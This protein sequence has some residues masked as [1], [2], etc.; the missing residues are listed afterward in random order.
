MWERLLE[1]LQKAWEWYGHI[2][3][4][5]SLYG[6]IFWLFPAGGFVSLLAWLTDFP[7]PFIVLLGFAGY[8]IGLCVSNQRIWRANYQKTKLF[9]KMDDLGNH[10]KPRIKVYFDAENPDYVFSSPYTEEDDDGRLILEGIKHRALILLENISTSSSLEGIEVYCTKLVAM[11]SEE[12]DINVRWTQGEYPRT[13][14]PGNTL[15]VGI[16]ELEKFTSYYGRE[17]SEEL[18]N[19]TI[20]WRC[21]HAPKKG[22]KFEMAIRIVGK[23]EPKKEMNFEFGLSDKK[24]YIKRLD[25]DPP[26]SSTARAS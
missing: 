1:R 3:Q 8:G 11:P 7:W 22:A 23:D 21:P 5:W 4:A 16:V 18:F 9:R 17:E 2:D 15:P 20:P 24:F 19:I 14:Q 10:I 25:S 6:V 13:L 12:R 26:D